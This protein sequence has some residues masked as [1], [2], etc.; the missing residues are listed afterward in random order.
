MQIQQTMTIFEKAKRV[1]AWLGSA[2]PLTTSAFDLMREVLEYVRSQEPVVMGNTLPG[3]LGILNLP[4]D[5]KTE[6][7]KLYSS[8]WLRRTWVRQE[9][10]AA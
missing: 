3:E 5:M 9:I 2:T 10:F 7:R 4:Q 1:L 6:L 8:T